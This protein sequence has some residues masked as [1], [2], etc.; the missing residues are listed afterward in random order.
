[1]KIYIYLNQTPYNSFSFFEATIFVTA[2]PRITA[3][4][5]VAAVFFRVA[6]AAVIC[7]PSYNRTRYVYFPLMFSRLYLLFINLFLAKH[8]FVC[9]HFTLCCHPRKPQILYAATRNKIS[10]TN[11]FRFLPLC[12]RPIIFNY[13]FLITHKKLH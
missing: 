5:H 2:N 9:L 11:S 6:L 13:L 7:L 10:S 1:M 4:L 3:I 12:L 8:L